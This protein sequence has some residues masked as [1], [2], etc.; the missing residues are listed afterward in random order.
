M[1]HQPLPP[2][3]QGDPPLP[4][5]FTKDMVHRKIIGGGVSGEGDE[6]DQPPDPFFALPGA[7]HNFD[8]GGG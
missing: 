5:L 8:P 6:P 7:G 3:L 1:G 4:S 2:P